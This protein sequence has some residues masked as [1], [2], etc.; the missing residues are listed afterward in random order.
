MIATSSGKRVVLTVLLTASISNASFGMRL[1]YP[2]NKTN[3][4]EDL[5][6]QLAANFSEADKKG[7]LVMDLKPPDSQLLPF[8]PWLADQLSSS[9]VNQDPRVEVVD[10][11]RLGAE[12]EAQHLSSNDVLTVKNDI[13][14]ARAVGATII[15]IGT[16]GAAENGVGVS[17]R[18]FRVSEFGV[19]GSTKFEVTRVFGKIP[20]TPDVSSHLSV[21]LDSLRPKDGIYKAGIG[22]VSVP[23]CVKCRP[24]DMHVPDIDLQGLLRGKGGDWTIAL[25]FVV[26]ADG[27]ANQITVTQPVGYGVDE[28]YVKAA[29]DWEFKPAVD[30][31][32]RP[33]A[34]LWNITFYNKRK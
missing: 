28:Q 32:H 20:F 5:A 12:M 2:Q 15:V 27:H 14:I 1:A 30:A 8:G 13:D 25:Q 9:L 11:A 19:P 6:R 34:A 18:A 21:P 29:K 24:P 17:L 23:A 33:V 4:T 16:Y 31:D 3:E 26:T 10:R 7:V 22:G